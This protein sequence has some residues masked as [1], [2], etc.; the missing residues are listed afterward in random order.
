MV[1][2]FAND[3]AFSKV[4]LHLLPT[5]SQ[6]DLSLFPNG[7]EEAK[8]QWENGRGRVEP[9]LPLAFAGSKAHVGLFLLTHG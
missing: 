1:L 4:S 3:K 2:P 8:V 6:P 9:G 7:D 5:V